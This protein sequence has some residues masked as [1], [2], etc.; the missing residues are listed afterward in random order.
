MSLGR[1]LR[2]EH[3]GAKN[4]GGFWGPREDA[5]RVSRRVRR[6]RDRKAVEPEPAAPNWRELMDPPP[7][8]D[9]P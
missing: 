2:T 8:D 5:K 3:A 7:R 9:E 1:R 4:G 6:R